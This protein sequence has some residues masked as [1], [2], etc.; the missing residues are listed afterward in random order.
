MSKKTLLFLLFAGTFQLYSAPE[1]QL[2]TLSP[3]PA[4]LIK[5]IAFFLQIHKAACLART[6]KNFFKLIDITQML[7]H[8]ILYGY[9]SK[10]NGW[11]NKKFWLQGLR[12]H[13]IN[14]QKNQTDLYNLREKKLYTL[15]KAFEEAIALTRNLNNEKVKHFLANNQGCAAFLT[16][17][18]VQALPQEIITKY[19]LKLPV[20]IDFAH[21]VITHYSTIWTLNHVPPKIDPR[22]NGSKIFSLLKCCFGCCLENENPE[23]TSSIT[24]TL[25]NDTLDLLLCY[26]IFSL[27]SKTLLPF[28]YLSAKQVAQLPCLHRQMIATAR[29]NF[30]AAIKI[31]LLPIIGDNCHSIQDLLELLKQA[32]EQRF[33]DPKI[34]M[35]LRFLWRFNSFMQLPV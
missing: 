4:E 17:K 23:G 27:L 8:A 30:F 2:S 6:S 15:I 14:E 16:H 19:I 25:A 3:L 31:P 1:K 5:Q 21:L 26:A 32:L 29:E 13:T 7:T 20:I 34:V 10:D 9:V 24:P 12:N 11:L 22:Q 18:Q 28:A 33:D 35:L